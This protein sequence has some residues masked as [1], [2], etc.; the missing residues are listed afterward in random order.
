MFML[1]CFNVFAFTFPSVDKENNI[2]RCT[3]DSVLQS[4]QRKRREERRVRIRDVEQVEKARDSSQ[5]VAECLA[6]S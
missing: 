6:V 1:D 3:I 5:L 4:I 2:S